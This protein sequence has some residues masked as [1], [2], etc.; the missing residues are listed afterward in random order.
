MPGMP[1]CTYCAA[2]PDEDEGAIEC[3]LTRRE[4]E[5]HEDAQDADYALDLGF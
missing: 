5:Q 1:L 4:I 3:Y 2:G